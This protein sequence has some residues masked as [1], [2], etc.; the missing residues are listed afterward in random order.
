MPPRYDRTTVAG[1][2]AALAALLL[3]AWLAGGVTRGEAIGFDAPV[4]AAVHS[5]TTPALTGA[6]RTFTILGS[7]PCVVGLGAI[8]VWRLVKAGRRRAAIVLAIA[9]AGAQV[10]N[11]VLKFV[12]QRARP[13]AFF[14]FPDPVTYSFPSGHAITAASFCGVLAAIV[15]VREKRRAAR[16]AVW[17]AAV[18]AAAAI[19]LSRVYLGVHYPSDVVAGYAVA[20]VWLAALRAAYGMWRRRRAAPR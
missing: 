10:L 12:F 19:G 7:A 11:Q 1:F 6:M 17:C 4:R 2:A 16:A 13:E 20:V 5:L 18:L 15:A 3:F 14:G 8:L 9:T